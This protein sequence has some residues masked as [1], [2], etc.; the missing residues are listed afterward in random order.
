MKNLVT[1]GTGFLGSHLVDKL[2]KRGEE[3]IC[4][5]NLSTGNINNI[6]HLINNDSFQ[7]IEHDVID[8]IE[9]DCERIW[10]LA[11]PASPIQYQKDPI[12]TTKTS[13]LGTYN[14]LEVALRNKARIFF[15]STS[16]IYGDPEVS[17]QQESYKGSVNPIGT[18]SCY[19]EGKRVAESLCFDYFRAH[20]VEIRIA[21]IFNTY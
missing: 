13:F 5:D 20:D 14:M 16:E 6:S 10:H 2:I 18:R 8:P 7:F 1:G 19:D 15:A 17:P 4:I 21:R 12:Q 11:C 9:I 3:V